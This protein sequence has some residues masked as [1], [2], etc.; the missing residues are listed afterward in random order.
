MAQAMRSLA[1]LKRICEIKSVPVGNTAEEF[2]TVM[3]NDL[4]AFGK[5]LKDAKWQRTSPAADRNFREVTRH[6]AI[7]VHVPLKLRRIQR[8]S[9]LMRY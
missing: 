3:K 8:P 1:V 6:G 7:G 2:R 9:E 5:I 4:D